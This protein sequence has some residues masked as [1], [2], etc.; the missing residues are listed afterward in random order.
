M[1]GIGISSLGFIAAIL[2]VIA[3]KCCNIA[4][5]EIIMKFLFSLSCGAL[6]GDAVIHILAETFA[7]EEINQK[8]VSLIFIASIFLFLIFDRL[9]HSFGIA[10]AHWV[11]EKCEG[12]QENHGHHHHEL[13]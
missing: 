4:C 12:D 9:L 8:I 13:S 5:F 1:A 11:G 6:I 10:H 2:L 7:N 3:K